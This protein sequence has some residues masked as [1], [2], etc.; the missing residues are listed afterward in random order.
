VV[1]GGIGSVRGAFVAAL[2]VGQLE[3]VG[4]AVAPTLAPFLLFGVMLA[5]LTVRVNDRPAAG[6][7]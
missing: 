4:V 6:T 5:V 7:P 1:V 3:T 2:G